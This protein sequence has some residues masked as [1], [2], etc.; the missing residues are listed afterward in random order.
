[1]ISIRLLKHS[2]FANNSCK[3]LGL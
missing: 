1:M 3:Q 2:F